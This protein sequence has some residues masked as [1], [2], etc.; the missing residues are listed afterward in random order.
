MENLQDSMQKSKSELQQKKKMNGCL[1]ALLIATGVF[2]LLLFIGVVFGDDQTEGSPT[3]NDSTIVESTKEVIESPKITWT[4]TEEVD[5]MTDAVSKWATV[6]S[7]NYIN[8]EFPYQGETFAEIVVRYMKKYGTDVMI[9]I[10]QGQIIGNEY[11]GT[12]YITVR[13]D[14]DAPKKYYFNEAADLSTET[15]F[16]TNP[17]SF[18]EDCK[19]AKNIK[20]EIPLYQAGRPLFR[21]YVDESLVW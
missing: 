12:N 16:L 5:E 1:K 20:V 7:D 10:T 17:K 3:T 4:Y 13:F 14:E 2:F 19:K 9:K 8:Q 21:F 6:V 11:N 18:I 15:V